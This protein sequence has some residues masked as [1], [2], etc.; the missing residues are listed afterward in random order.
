MKTLILVI[1]LLILFKPVY[2]QK[3]SKFNWVD[4]SIN[5]KIRCGVSIAASVL[6]MSALVNNTKKYTNQIRPKGIFHNSFSSQQT[7]YVFLYC[8][9]S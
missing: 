7:V 3:D 1:G 9:F 4:T 8:I 5:K 6:L 2:S